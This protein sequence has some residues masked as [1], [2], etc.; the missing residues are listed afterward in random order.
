VSIAA[1][2]ALTVA[3]AGPTAWLVALGVLILLVIVL[4]VGKDVVDNDIDTGDPAMV[5]PEVKGP[6]A[7]ESAS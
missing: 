1:L 7:G 6:A 5:V 2:A 3:L 4:S